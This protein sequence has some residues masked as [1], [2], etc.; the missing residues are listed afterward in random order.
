MNASMAGREKHVI[1]VSGFRYLY[2]CNKD[3]LG[4]LYSE[5]VADTALH[6]SEVTELNLGYTPLVSLPFCESH[7]SGTSTFFICL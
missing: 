6:N 4:L 5:M 3:V 7:N 1:K 2:T